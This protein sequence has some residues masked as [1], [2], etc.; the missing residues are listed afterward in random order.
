MF[1]SH[2]NMDGNSYTLANNFRGPTGLISAA[3]ANNGSG[4]SSSSLYTIRG[5]VVNAGI[6]DF[7][8]PSQDLTI[9]QVKAMEAGC[10]V[11][12]NGS[13]T[14][15]ITDAYNFYSKGAVDSSGTSTN[16]ITNLYGFYHDSTAGTNNYAFYDNANALSR[17]GAVILANQASDPSTVTD[18]A[19][20]YAKDDAGSSEVYVR[21]EAGNVTQISPHNEAGEWQYWSQNVKTGKK[22]RINM[23]R[24]I[25]KLEEITGET[26]IENE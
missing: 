17:F 12:T 24:M 2:T 9:T 13:S 8:S 1:T 15:T 3:T 5:A 23:E 11:E 26:F 21:D 22:V 14:N 19:H 18:S 6:S 4:S 7:D 16:T 25:R 20:I 10:G